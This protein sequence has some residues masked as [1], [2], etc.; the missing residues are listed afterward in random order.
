MQSYIN[1]DKNLIVNTAIDNVK[2][3]WHDVRKKPFSLHGFYEHE[4]LQRFIRMP[5]EVAFSVS[6]TVGKLCKESAGG[7]VRFTTNSPYIAIRAK[8]SAVGR[9]PHLTMLSTV[10]FDLYMEGEF[11]SRFFKE[12]RM[13]YDITDTYEQIVHLENSTKR[14]YTINFPIRSVV[15]TLEIGLEPNS[16]LTEPL[17]YRDIEPLVFYGSSIV[18]GVGAS[19]P[20]LTYPAIISRKLNIDYRNIG[21]SG[22]ALGESV[23]VTHAP[24]GNSPFQSCLGYRYIYHKI[25]LKKF[26]RQFTLLFYHIIGKISSVFARVFESYFADRCKN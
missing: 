4:Y 6:E 21:F 2:I 24:L 17:P 9:A 23:I 22:N 13:P 7:R 3:E 16:I 15:E 10:G 26:Y 12:F 8:F 19:R 20:G 11:G 14:T 18:H 1:L 25:R 5:E